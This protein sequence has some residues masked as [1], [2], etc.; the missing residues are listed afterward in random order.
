M[1]PG[2]SHDRYIAIMPVRRIAT[3]G[4]EA[5]AFR[6]YEG[7]DRAAFRIRSPWVSIVFH[8]SESTTLSFELINLHIVPSYG[9]LNI[10]SR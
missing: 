6:S 10:R 2:K 3:S 4:H 1:T 7:V 5:S 9:M 8:V